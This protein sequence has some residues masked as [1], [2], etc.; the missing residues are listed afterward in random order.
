MNRA[1]RYPIRSNS[2]ARSSSH[3][4]RDWSSWYSGRARMSWRRASAWSSPTGGKR[5]RLELAHP[6]DDVGALASIAQIDEEQRVH[7]R[8]DAGQ[9]D[10]RDECHRAA[11]GGFSW[12]QTELAA[13]GLVD[14]EG[15][16]DER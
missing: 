1:S 9:Q 8:A 5:R 3:H 16:G 13:K 11:D 7:D 4:G 12:R 14:G 2:G 6:L 15:D 10:A